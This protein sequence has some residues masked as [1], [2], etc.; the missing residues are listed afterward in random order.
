M[1]QKGRQF[2]I[3]EKDGIKKFRELL[4]VNPLQ[5]VHEKYIQRKRDMG[6]STNLAGI[7]ASKGNNKEG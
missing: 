4:Y 2:Y 5:K 3:W 1:K 6:I 7:K